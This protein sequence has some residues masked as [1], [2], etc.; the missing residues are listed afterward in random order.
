MPKIRK[1]EHSGDKGSHRKNGFWG[2]R[3]EAKRLGRKQRRVQD[4]RRIRQEAFVPAGAD[5][6]VKTAENAFKRHKHAMDKLK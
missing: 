3:A 2:K 6:F 4:K 5:Q 1:T